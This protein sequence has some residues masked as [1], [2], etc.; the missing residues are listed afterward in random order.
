M[1]VNK[2]KKNN[3]RQFLLLIAVVLACQAKANIYRDMEPLTLEK[4]EMKAELVDL[5]GQS[6]RQALQVHGRHDLRR[7]PSVRGRLGPQE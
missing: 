2:I 5:P 1:D 3:M 6:W 7:Y 4:P